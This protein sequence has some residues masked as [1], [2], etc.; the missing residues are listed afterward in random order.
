MVFLLFKKF[1]FNISMLTS[2]HLIVGVSIA[3]TTKD[4]GLTIP[5]ALVSHY[6]MDAIPHYNP[7]KIKSYKEKGL[8]NIN[9]KEVLS[10][11]IEPVIGLTLT[12]LF[13]L[14]HTSLTYLIL[15]GAGFAM[16]PDILT[17]IEWKLG[18]NSIINRID[19][20][21]HRH[22]GFYTG[23]IPQGLIMISCW[24]YIN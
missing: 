20:R 10:K 24:I 15:I 23:M 14:A 5:L 3:V 19:K 22:T 11:T 21:F 18:T 4:I 16:L 1:Q 9:K 2:A 8:K 7:G 17:F 6:I 12:V 13:A